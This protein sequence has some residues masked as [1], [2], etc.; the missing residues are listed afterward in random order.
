MSVELTIDGTRV[1]GKKGQT[2][3]EVAQEN[4]IHIPTLCHHSLL[5]TNG[6][7][8]IC[9]VDIGRKD[10]L[11][12]ACTTPITNDMKVETKS[13][14]VLDARRLNLELLLSNHRADCVTCE[15]DGQCILQDL[16]YELELDLHKTAFKPQDIDK[17]V[18]DS[19]PAILYDPNMC[20]LCG[21]CISACNNIRHHNVL[22]YKNR[23][24][25]TLVIAGLGELFTDSDCVNCGECI[26]VCPTGALTEKPSRF[27]GRWKEL[28]MTETTCPY[29]GVGCTLELYTKDNTIV[30][31]KGK[32]DAL[33]NQGSLCVKGRFGYD[34]VNS[35]ERLTTPLVRDDF[36]EF[37]E[38]T[39][40]EALDLVAGKLAEVKDQYGA[41]SIMGLASAKCTNEENYV[42]QKFFRACIGT[43]SV[44]HCA[45]LCHAP[46]VAGLVKAFGSGAMTN[47]IQEML[48]TDCF[49]VIGSNTTE[50]HPVIA[51]YIRQAVLD[52]GAKLVVADPRKI[53]LVRDSS[54]WLRQRGGTDVAL[55]NGLMNVIIEENLHDEAF[56][57]E[58]TE[59]YEELKNTVEKYTPERV[60]RITGVPADKLREAARMYAKAD[61][62][63][64]IFS[65]GITQHTT[66]TD[67]V[68]STANLAMLT[69]NVGKHGTGVNPLRGQNNVQGA[70]DLGALPNVYSGYQSVEDPLIRRK[71]EEAWGAKLDERNGLTMV[72]AFNAVSRGDVQAMYIMGENPMVSEPDLTHVEESLKKLGF[73]VVQDLFLTETAQYADVVLPSC[74]FAEK[75]G[76]FTN[77]ARR[78]QMVRKAVEPPGNSRLDWQILC[79]VATR[80][81]YPL[82][83]GSSA[84]IMK[85]I[86][87][88]TPIYGGVTHERLQKTG[89]QWPCPVF[90]HPGTQFLHR[91]KFS[92]GL[93]RFHGVEYKPAEE[94]P[95]EDF[96]Y[97]LTTGRLLQHFH[98]GTMTR[99]SKVLDT[100]VPECPIEINPADA[101]SLG[102]ADG[103]L[104]EV[105]SRRGTITGKTSVTDRSDLGTVFIPFHFAEAAANVLTNPA[106][107]PDSKIPELKVCAVRLRKP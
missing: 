45:R 97:M 24:Y 3:L 49:L 52:R 42:F 76:T 64:I 102:L 18:D 28:E 73:L 53:G 41:R 33:E 15:Q 80:M 104:V 62:A 60:E 86:A 88:V 87:S 11:E 34:W 59:N 57:I 83:Y 95:D 94:L 67:N 70:C 106:L 30:K 14:R 107:D 32:E 54:I 61:R 69:G 5:P 10:R 22:S 43:N 72:E 9:V 7:C 74:S 44:D 20:V 68:L 101:D 27:M 23:G 17:P 26:Q 105:S 12:A 92:R 4:R 99:R 50:N 38:A 71:F 29:C 31:I 36:G 56:I 6:A 48:D 25:D 39:W 1:T 40:D 21:R 81:G 2:I 47:S 78:V 66:G 58:R 46:T 75:N 51:K 96:P 63:S 55:L 100:L 89:L 93:G 82:F 77:T 35:P 37:R 65:M 103:D 19:S 98:T 13:K 79:E 16:A 84:E 8:R 91:H 90:D 85:E